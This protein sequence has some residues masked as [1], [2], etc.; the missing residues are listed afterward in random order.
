LIFLIFLLLFIIIS[1]FVWYSW[2]RKNSNFINYFLLFSSLSLIA[3]RYHFAYGYDTLLHQAS[4]DYIARHGQITPLSPFY[5]G[6]YSLEIFL[7]FFTGLNFVFI[8]RWFLPVL[9]AIVLIETGKYF[10][11]FIS[12]SHAKNFYFLIPLSV[13]I[14]IPS[15]FVITSPS[16]T[17]LIFT[18]PGAVFLYV[19]FLERDKSIFYLALGSSISAVL[20]H[21]F[22]GLNIL[23]WVLSSSFLRRESPLSE[24]IIY[25]TVN[26]FISSF[27]STLCFIFYNFL[28]RGL[29]IHFLNPI[30]NIDRFFK[31]FKNPLWYSIGGQ[32]F[33]ILT[34]YFF[35]K[36]SLFLFL[37]ISV[38]IVISCRK[39]LNYLLLFVTFS[40]VL[41]SLIFVSIFDSASF[42]DGD[43]INYGYRLFQISKWIIWPIILFG[44]FK[45][46]FFLRDKS[47]A[48]R[49]SLIFIFSVFFLLGLYL[50]Y[51]RYDSIS[52]M[53]AN[54][55]RSVDY[56]ALDIIHNRENGKDGY[57]VLS[58]QIL[59]AGAVKKFGFGPYY[60]LDQENIMYFSIPW[61]GSLANLYNKVMTVENDASDV[62]REVRKIAERVGVNRF[63]FIFTNNWMPS[64]EIMYD[65]DREA[66]F[67][68]NINNQVLIYQFNVY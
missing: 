26:I 53:S 38:L 62:F 10:L 41:S 64:P 30:T 28:S 66:E 25:Y 27:F 21:P 6:Q 5:I 32:S 49:A 34:I 35:E 45:L 65:F 54:S 47:L 18:I 1:I 68:K 20:I 37:F 29:S 50:T 63:Y 7:H 31:I 48:S 19:Y 12:R 13:I 9:S 58:N 51:P 33:G 39:K 43:K 52:V 4:L 23:I 36:I 57:L 8:E 61:G 14:L 44:L 56:D 60:K 42:Y 16:A 3:L 55:I 2:Q 11:N 22:I 67:F 17:S 59:G 40:F 24:R 15:L 46:F